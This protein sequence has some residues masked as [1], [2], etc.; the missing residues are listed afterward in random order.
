M[1]TQ[2][3]STEPRKKPNMLS[4][5]KDFIAFLQHIY[6]SRELLSALIKNDFRKQYLGSYLGLIWAFT[7]PLSYLIVIWFVFDVG[8]K[9]PPTSNGTPYFLWLACGMIPWLFISSVITSGTN[10]ITNNAYM[11][12]KVAFRVSVLPL[13][14]IGSA[15]IIHIG[16]VAFLI[17]AL[18]IH[19]HKPTVHWL[20]MPFYMLCAMVWLLGLTWITSAI[21]VF[22]KDIGNLM[23]VLV[24]L[25]FW[26]TPIFWSIDMLPKRLQVIFEINPAYYIVNGYRDSF[27]T[28]AW[29]W[30]KPEQLLT[31]AGITFASL[32]IGALIFKR[33]RP[34]F[35]DVL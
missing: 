34:H 3:L 9:A 7:Q 29:F 6:S 26:A 33:L 16:L 12:K 17:V 20:Q 10:A 11:V 35:G 31:F 1:S 32:L 22:I 24:Q 15:A 30:E 5:F 2:T 25:G 8:F 27:V 14:E 23:S 4:S 13:V 21:R 28:D 19:G 18:I